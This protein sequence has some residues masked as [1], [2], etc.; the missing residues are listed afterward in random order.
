MVVFLF[1]L[2]SRGMFSMDILKK[3]SLTQKIMMISLLTLTVPCLLFSFYLYK[4][5]SAF[6]YRQSLNERRLAM[7]QT[8]ETLN[9]IFDSVS[10]LS[11]DLAYGDPLNEYLAKQYRVDLAKYPTW[12]EQ[13]LEEV[14]SSLK[15]SL[16]YRNLGITAANI[17]VNN[18]SLQEGGYFWFADRLSDLPFFQDFAR[19]DEPA[20]LYYLD[21][22]QT[23]IFRSVRGYTGYSSEDETILLLRRIE[24]IHPRT[25][26]GYL[27]FELS[28]SEFFPASFSPESESGT[29]C[30]WFFRSLSGYGPAFPDN[31]TDSLKPSESP[32][33]YLE[34]GNK[35]Y[36]A[37]FTEQFNI[38]ILDTQPLLTDTF[39]LPALKLSLLLVFLALLQILIL[40]FYL[41]RIFRKI[42][43]DLNLMDSIIVHGFSGRIPEIRS[44]E[45]G[46]IAHR[47]NVLLDKIEI[48]IQ[49]TAKK[50]VLH[51]QTQLKA[52][53]YQINPHFIYN[54]LS[55]FSGYAAKKG[56]DELAD[57][58]ASFGQLLRY[59]IKNNESYSTVEEEIRNASSLMKIY[60]IRYFNQITLSVDM[61]AELSQR[62]ILK[63]LLQPLLENS[64]LHGLTS[65]RSAGQNAGNS[66]GNCTEHNAGHCSERNAGHYAKHNALHIDVSIK[67]VDTFLELTIRDDGAGMN[68]ERLAQVRRHMMDPSQESSDK[69]NGSFIGLYNIWKR[70]ELFY[71]HQAGIYIDSRE[72]SGTSILIRIPFCYTE[73]I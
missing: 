1:C 39:Q 56:E 4:E 60:N 69:S 22:A 48:L 15:Y 53:Q 17:Y 67:H 49:E 58:I 46:M 36:L 68:A 71:N 14:I 5:Q 11:M 6:L 40:S 28:P 42:H 30:A 35:Q 20:A 64:I 18:G 31:L 37:A 66:A 61:D 27:V 32:Y 9:T 26:L 72:N 33:L 44:D 43:K 59:T 50:E 70:L 16:N 51:T 10:A 47:Y 2:Y 13:Q 21:S 65:P 63:F 73:G 12:S 41:R 25:C 62:R 34:D 52:L 55:I 7:Q 54:T 3:R 38:A 23:D 45:I 29:Y 19:S 8:V 57:S 24:T